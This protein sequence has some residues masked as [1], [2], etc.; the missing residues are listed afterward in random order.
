MN[1]QLAPTPKLKMYIKDDYVQSKFKDVLGKKA[2]A[3]LASLLSVVAAN[4]E[5]ENVE[6]NTVINAAMIAATLDLPINQNLGLAYIIPYK[7]QAQFQMGAKGFKQLA[8]RTG[9]YKFLND[10]DVREGEFIRIDHLTGETIFNWIEDEK[11]RESKKIVGYVAYFELKD[12]FSKTLYMTTEKINAHAL[13]YSQ[14][15]KKNFGTWVDNLDAMSRK[16]VIKLLLNSY[17]LITTELAKA[18]EA[19]QAVIKGEDDYE[20]VDNEKQTP[21]DIAADK[22]RERIVEHIKTSKTVK[23]L[24]Q[25]DPSNIRDADVFDMYDAKKKELEKT[26]KGE[27]TEPK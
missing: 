2:P 15:Y 20:Y 27:V 6:P 3:F 24:Q 5:F 13:K 10:S 4:K 7:G 11:E 17:G 23:E 9:K 22:E 18:I 25:L 26:P 21:E 1:G 16:T 19:D 14:S 8:I 12:G